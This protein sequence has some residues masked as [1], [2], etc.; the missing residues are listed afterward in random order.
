MG[1]EFPPLRLI[2]PR[3]LKEEPGPPIHSGKQWRVVVGGNASGAFINDGLA[4]GSSL[5][6]RGVGVGVGLEG[7]GVEQGGGQ[8][9]PSGQTR[10]GLVLRDSE[11]RWSRTGS[12][13]QDTSG[14]GTERTT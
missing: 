3:S 14:G 4:S 5:P 2:R 7:G 6:G 8:R 11:R 10:T 12:V 13:E 9:G 1:S